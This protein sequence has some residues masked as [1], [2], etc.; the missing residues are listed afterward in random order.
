MCANVFSRMRVLF[1][2]EYT[3]GCFVLGPT[4]A[5]SELTLSSRKLSSNID[6][7]NVTDAIVSDGN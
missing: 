7:G 6:C 3:K 5:S 1:H 4:K 2:G